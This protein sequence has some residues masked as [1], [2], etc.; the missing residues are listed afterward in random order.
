VIP[1]VRV[2]AGHDL[3]S[4]DSSG[5]AEFAPVL[6]ERAERHVFAGL[7]DG[8]VRTRDRHVEVS[9]LWKSESR[10]GDEPLLL[11]LREVMIGSVRPL[12]GGFGVEVD[13][14]EPVLDDG[15]LLDGL[16]KDVLGRLASTGR[17][18][19]AF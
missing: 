15:R 7:V 9:Q 13:V 10:I 1:S 8:E 16:S 3:G 14:I 4:V 17:L 18:P 19:L 11:V 12:D 6:L 2:D 5:D